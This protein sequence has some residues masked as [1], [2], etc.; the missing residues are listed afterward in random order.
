MKRH[1]LYVASLLAIATS[2]RLVQLLISSLPYNIDSFAQVAI[3]E[4]VLD[5]GQW[6]LDPTSSNAVNLKVPLLPLLLASIASLTGFAPLDLAVP[7]AIGVSLV[8]ILGLY[9]LVWRL[10]GHRITAWM[11]GLVLALLGPYIF[12]SGTLMKEAF[13]LALLPALLWLTWHRQ[14]PRNRVMAAALLLVLPLIHHLSTLMAFGMISF[15][16]L[17]QNA[18]AYWEDRWSW[19]EA[20]KDVVFGP[21][22]FPVAL[23]YYAF[24]G[25]EGFTEVWK[26]DEVALFLAVALL[27][28]AAGLLLAS[29]K[30][31]R[32]WFALSKARRRLS[33]L[34]QKT[35]AIAGAFLLVLV[36]LYLPIF[37]GTVATS[38]LLLLG[39]LAY[40]PLV[41]LAVI[42]LNLFRLSNKREKV[43]P[44]VLL[45]APLTV[46]LYALLRG[47]DPLSH[48]ILY[49][50]VDFLDFGIAL[51]V[52]VAV[53][54]YR[55]RKR[56]VLVGVVV[57]A[58]LATVPMAYASERVFQVQNT[59]YAYEWA[60]LNHLSSTGA[61][62][63]Y[64]DQRL[65]SVMAWYFGVP[66]DGSLP[67]ILDLN[68]PLPRGVL[69]LEENWGSRGAQVFPFPFILI[70]EDRLEGLV[71]DHHLVYHGGASDNGLL[72]LLSRD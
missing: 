53:V 9:A 39:A 68:Q 10:T 65:A 25:M 42:G 50:S 27:M 69:L 45:L 32:P 15:V 35:V 62:A 51:T 12:N 17:L 28:A 72:I 55:G 29:N 11:A 38:P 47:L 46:I 16:I 48:V 70:E 59:T 54:S 67:L 26:P 41:F 56:R 66:A 13:G 33:L 30:R 64:T 21:A 61:P 49:R 44:V 3:A 71:A 40:L 6:S 52:A 2:I 60:A 37:P 57:V 18:Q 14:D 63:P 20:G 31:A 19:R 22:L 58:L 4:Q 43:V 34:D 24:V 23:A 5:T 1:L 7:V 8:G 36:N